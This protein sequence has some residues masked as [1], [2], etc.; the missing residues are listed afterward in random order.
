ME[1]EPSQA[2]GAQVA[3]KALG[4]NSSVHGHGLTGT[5]Q[6]I[7]VKTKP[8]NPIVEMFNAFVR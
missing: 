2:C 1:L 8:R 3:K 6:R 4:S 5:G 7:T